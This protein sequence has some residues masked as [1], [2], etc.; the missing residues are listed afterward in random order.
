MRMSGYP[1]KTEALSFTAK[2]KWLAT[3]GADAMVLWPFFGGGPMGVGREFM[4]FGGST[5]GFV[6][7]G[8]SSGVKIARQMSGDRGLAIVV[9]RSWDRLARGPMNPRITTTGDEAIGYPAR[10]GTSQRRAE[11]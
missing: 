5:M 6:H 9:W 4:L 10:A 2:G 11:S 1:A 3:S 8:F 7:G